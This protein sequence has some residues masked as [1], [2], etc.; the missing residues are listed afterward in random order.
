MKHSFISLGPLAP[1]VSLLRLRGAARLITSDLI[2]VAGAV[3]ITNLT[4]E[5]VQQ[6]RGLRNEIFFDYD[7]NDVKYDIALMKVCHT[8][9]IMRRSLELR[10]HV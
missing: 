3:S 5:R 1:A 8:L 9:I 10:E 7:I 2:I 6:R 4:D